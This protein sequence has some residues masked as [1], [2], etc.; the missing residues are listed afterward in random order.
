MVATVAVAAA[1]EMVGLVSRRRAQGEGGEVWG[2][3]W[4]W[5]VAAAAEMAVSTRVAVARW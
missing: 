5:V 1:V 3:G 4:G 2:E